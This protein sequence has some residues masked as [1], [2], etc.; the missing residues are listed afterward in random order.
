M[1]DKLLTDKL[2][3]PVTAILHQHRDRVLPMLG[4]NAGTLARTALQNDEAVR[5]VAAY[6]YQVLPGLLR[7]AVK[8][9]AFIAFVMTHR[10]QLLA[11]LL[12]PAPDGA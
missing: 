1:N 4:G 8:E 2:S 7:L 9:P 3:G 6:C 12:K 5:T 11:A 10:Q